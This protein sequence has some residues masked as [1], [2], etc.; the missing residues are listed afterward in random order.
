[1]TDLSILDTLGFA[2]L[3]LVKWFWSERGC[4]GQ[5]SERSEHREECGDL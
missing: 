5:G 1:M 2:D 4:I 3:E